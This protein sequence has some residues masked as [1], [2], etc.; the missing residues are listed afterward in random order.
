MPFTS[1]DQW[2]ACFATKGFG[3]KVDC[4]EWANKSKSFKDLPK[5]KPTKKKMQESFGTWMKNNHP[6]FT[7]LDQ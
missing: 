2:K 3:G 4:E 5:K 1:Q 6:E 7:I